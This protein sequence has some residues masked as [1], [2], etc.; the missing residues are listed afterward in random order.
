MSIGGRLTIGELAV[1]PGFRSPHRSRQAGGAWPGMR[2]SGG[3]FSASSWAM[4][5]AAAKSRAA[6]SIS[7]VILPLRRMSASVATARWS[8]TSCPLSG[9]RSAPSPSAGSRAFWPVSAHG[10]AR[11]LVRATAGSCYAVTRATTAASAAGW[12]A[13]SSPFVHSRKESRPSQFP[14][15]GKR[16]HERATQLV[17]CTA[18]A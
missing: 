14:D 16:R 2:A 10:V 15:T 11:K 18:S 3:I 13:P 4:V 1:R 17:S 8:V 7:G 12:R 6:A 5:K 9:S